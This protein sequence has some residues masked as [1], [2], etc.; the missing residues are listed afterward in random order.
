MIFRQ[1]KA[2]SDASGIRSN[3]MHRYMEHS[4]GNPNFTTMLYI[5]REKNIGA[6]AASNMSAASPLMAAK[7]TYKLMKGEEYTRRQADP[8]LDAITIPIAAAGLVLFIVIIIFLMTQKK[9]LAK[10]SVNMKKEK[11][12]LCLRLIIFTL[13]LAIS[14]AAPYLIGYN[15]LFLAVWASYSALIAL[16]ILDIDLLMMIVIHS[17]SNT[18]TYNHKIKHFHCYTA[19]SYHSRACRETCSR[20]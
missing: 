16:T 20:C 18:Q 3:M 15:Y 14:L 19:F 10:K 1:R 12:R 13:L 8:S 5:D 7:S 17:N 9:R 6:F 4:G 11:V 2:I